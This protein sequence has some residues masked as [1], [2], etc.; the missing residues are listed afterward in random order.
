MKVSSML[1]E[2]DIF[3]LLIVHMSGEISLFMF[4]FDR[5]PAT[6]AG[7]VPQYR[8]QERERGKSRRQRVL[9][10]SE[11][12]GCGEIIHEEPDQVTFISRD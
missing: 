11:F 3:Q 4:D 7:A 5:V 9:P 12:H 6:S 2:G 1:V 10:Q 8:G